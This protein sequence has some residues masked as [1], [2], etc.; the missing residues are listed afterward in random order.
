MSNNMFWTDDV[1]SVGLLYE[2]TS[3]LDGSDRSFCCLYYTNRAL[4]N[5][6]EK[7]SQSDI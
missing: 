5:M 6:V 7:E 3:S 4:S 2:A 1:N